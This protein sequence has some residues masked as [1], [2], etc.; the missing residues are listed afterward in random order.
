M[1]KECFKGYCVRIFCEKVWGVMLPIDCFAILLVIDPMWVMR[2]F[3]HLG[4]VHELSSLT[5]IHVVSTD[6]TPKYPQKN[7]NKSKH[8]CSSDSKEKRYTRTWDLFRFFWGYFVAESGTPY[9][10]HP[11]KTPFF[12]DFSLISGV[13]PIKSTYNWDFWGPG[14]G[15]EISLF[16]SRIYPEF[17]RMGLG[18]SPHLSA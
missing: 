18:Y 10:T 3:V 8:S 16:F 15:G 13:S 6:P 1:K 14:G 4:D 5:R 9:P 2:S 11:P 7:R 17:V 12:P